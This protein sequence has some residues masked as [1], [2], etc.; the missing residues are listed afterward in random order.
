MK[1]SVPTRNLLIRPWK[2]RSEEAE[3]EKK[4]TTKT[5]EQTFIWDYRTL[6]A[7][8]SA[9]LISVDI[10]HPTLT[11]APLCAGFARNKVLFCNFLDS[12]ERASEACGSRNH[13]KRMFQSPVEGSLAAVALAR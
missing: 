11:G 4:K 13:V 10:L 5:T 12:K 1:R 6:P 3:K 9:T 2:Q 7:C 8:A